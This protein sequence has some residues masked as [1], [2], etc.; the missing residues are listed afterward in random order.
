MLTAYIRAAMHQARYEMIEDEQPFYG[1]IPECPG[2]WA[3][4]RT[5]EECRDELQETLEEW[6]SLGLRLGHPVPEIDG[7]RI[8]SG[9]PVPVDV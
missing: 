2:V 6:L 1:H 5:L 8:V 3:T 7:I 4:G 9:A